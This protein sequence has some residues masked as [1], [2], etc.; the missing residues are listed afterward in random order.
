MDKAQIFGVLN[1]SLFL[2]RGLVSSLDGNWAVMKMAAKKVLSMGLLQFR[3]SEI[4]FI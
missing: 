4:S 3:V 1:I 2:E